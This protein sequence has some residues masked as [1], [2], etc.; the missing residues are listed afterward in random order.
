MEE[1][2]KEQPVIIA[3]L[4]IVA[5]YIIRP[6]VDALTAR[7]KAMAVKDKLTADITKEENKTEQIMY[8]LLTTAIGSL[9]NVMSEVVNALRS[10]NVTNERHVQFMQAISG[11]Q[12]LQTYEIGKTKTDILGRMDSMQMALE[13]RH[14]SAEGVMK[15]NFETIR[16]GL[17]ILLM[18][19]NTTLSSF[20]DE[21]EDETTPQP[22][23]P[24]IAPG[25]ESSER[26]ND[27]AVV[28][29]P[30]SPAD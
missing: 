10:M 2:L 30:A 21:K 15:E 5:H 22:E 27:S 16:N 24:T 6:F 25:L 19:V 29:V 9:Q 13:S 20:K 4:W 8:S 12:T 18:E 7:D 1:L 11:Q 23:Q 26:A 14:Q 3:I 17:N 28:N